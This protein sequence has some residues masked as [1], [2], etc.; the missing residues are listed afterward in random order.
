MNKLLDENKGQHWPLPVG[1]FPGFDKVR[2]QPSVGAVL[3]QARGSLIG[4][5]DFLLTASLRFSLIAA[6]VAGNLRWVHDTVGDLIGPGS[7]NGKPAGHAPH[8]GG[9][10]P[11]GKAA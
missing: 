3:D 1:L 7:P 8:S 6:I 5:G 2:V 10:S 9:D 11:N 4:R